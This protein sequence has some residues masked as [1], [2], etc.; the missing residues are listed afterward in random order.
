MWN[1]FDSGRILFCSYYYIFFYLYLDH[2]EQRGEPSSVQG[3]RR[4]ACS[5]LDAKQVQK[6]YLDQT[7]F[8]DDIVGVVDD[9]VVGD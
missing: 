9:V 7:R 8:D 4:I 3:R 1:C 5:G 2:R 6:D